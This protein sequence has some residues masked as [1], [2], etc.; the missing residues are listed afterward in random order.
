MDWVAATGR[1][2][3]VWYR[4]LPQM[5]PPETNV[6]EY[7]GADDSWEREMAEFIDDIHTGREPAAGLADAIAALKVVAGIYS[8]SGHDHRA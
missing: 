6:W 3:C 1:R 5:G 2:S 4:M 7:P 8:G